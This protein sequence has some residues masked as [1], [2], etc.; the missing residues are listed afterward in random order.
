MQ[1]WQTNLALLGLH[2]CHAQGEKCPWNSS[3]AT[4]APSTPSLRK[5]RPLETDGAFRSWRFPI[6]CAPSSPPKGFFSS[7][8][9]HNVLVNDILLHSWRQ[10][11]QGKDR[12]WD[13]IFFSLCKSVPAGWSSRKSGKW[14]SIKFPTQRNFAGS[15]QLSCCELHVAAM[16]W[17]NSSLDFR[18]VGLRVLSMMWLKDKDIL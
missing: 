4:G 3:A 16:G 13:L 12:K 14:G 9:I 8:Q 17:I 6:P 1:Q 15:F 18:H 10:P 7:L 5:T 11:P 2:I